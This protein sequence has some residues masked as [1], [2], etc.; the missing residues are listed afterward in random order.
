MT[1]R[2]RQRLL[3]VGFVVAGVAVSAALALRAFQENLEYF[4]SPTQIKA[5]EAP[6]GRTLRVGG[7]VVPGSVVREE[8]S[9]I[10]QFD[11]TDPHRYAGCVVALAGQVGL[12]PRPRAVAET[13]AAPLTPSVRGAPTGPCR[14]SGASQRSTTRANRGRTG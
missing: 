5:G 3:L 13:V 6:A 4:F 9:L 12:D 11:L 1:P 8:G 2:R 7:L 10:I 14:T